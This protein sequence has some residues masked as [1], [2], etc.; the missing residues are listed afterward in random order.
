MRL[1]HLLSKESEVFVLCYVFN[2][3]ALHAQR[4]NVDKR[5]MYTQDFVRST[6]RVRENEAEHT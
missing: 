6:R 2:N 4:S 5:Q 3:D 1:D